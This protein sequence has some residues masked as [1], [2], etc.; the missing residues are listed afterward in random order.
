MYGI[1]QIQPDT[2]VSASILLV[3]ALLFIKVA[4]SIHLEEMS[5]ALHK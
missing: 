5:T 3:S 2:C 1:W 4:I